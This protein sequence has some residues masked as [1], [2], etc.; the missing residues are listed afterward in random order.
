MWNAMCKKLHINTQYVCSGDQRP[1]G[2]GLVFYFINFERLA[3]IYRGS[4]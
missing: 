1:R 4:P 2:E 3:L